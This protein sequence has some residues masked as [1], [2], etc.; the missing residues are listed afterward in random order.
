VNCIHEWPNIKL[1][2]DPIIHIRTDCLTVQFLLVGDEVLRRCL[3]TSFLHALDSLGHHDALKVRIRAETLPI[4]ASLSKFPER[5]CCRAE[6][7]M[8][9]QLLGLSAEEKT[10]F[11]HK[12]DVPC[13]S[14]VDTGGEGSGAL[15]I[16]D[17]L[18]SICKC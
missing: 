6:L 17:A 2:Q 1:P 14:G 4:A 12:V 15:D 9:T 5:S 10:T 8:N 3:N 16:T 11:T 13:A 18:W 7:D